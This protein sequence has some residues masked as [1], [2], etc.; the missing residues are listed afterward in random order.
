[1]THGQ[2]HDWFFLHS[3]LESNKNSQKN[4]PERAALDMLL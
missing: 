2:E 3:F 1:M 4:I